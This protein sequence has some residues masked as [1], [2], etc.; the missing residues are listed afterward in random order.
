MIDKNADRQRQRDKPRIGQD[1]GEAGGDPAL[2]HEIAEPLAIF[3]QGAE[4][5]VAQSAK[6]DKQNP[7]EDQQ[8]KRDKTAD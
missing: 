4:A 3:G 2:R 5:S 8:A 6:G 7:G 1:K